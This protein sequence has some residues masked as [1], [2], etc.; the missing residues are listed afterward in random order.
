MKQVQENETTWNSSKKTFLLI[1]ALYLASSFVHVRQKPDEIR[2]LPHLVIGRI[3]LAPP[4]VLSG[5]SPHYLASVNSLLED[6]DFDLRNNYDQSEKGSLDLGERFRGAAI[7]RHV[8]RDTRGREMGTHSPFFALLLSLLL[9]PLS[10]S[11]WVEPASIWAG[12]LAALAGIF[13][14]GRRFSIEQRGFWMM[15][16]ALATPLWC[17]ARDLW[18]EPWILLIWV[19]M[20]AT[21][22][23]FLVCLLAF[24][25]TLIKYPFVVVPASMA[26]VYC[27]R[28]DWKRALALAGTSVL[29]IGLVIGSI[30]ILFQNVP[31]FSLFHSGVHAGFH[32]LPFRGGVGLLLDPEDGLL[33][34]FPFLAW[35]LLKFGRGG[36]LYLPALSFF[37]VHACYNDWT[38][39]TG[40][41]ARY[42]VPI[43]P[44]MLLAIQEG[45]PRDRFF[46]VALA[47][48]LF[49][50]AFGGFFPALVYDRTP[51]GVMAHL[52]RFLFPGAG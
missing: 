11:A 52:F 44:I 36:M 21:S 9:W 31:H 34:F 46:R 43:L 49:W 5:D 20:L 18:T 12:T 19:A 41:S 14:F 32:L 15:T 37:L 33:F 8:D 40:F 35:G 26:L 13:V 38:G 39:G 24:L 27:Y 48:G 28:K 30:Q 16:L 50:G 7:D 6:H 23:L 3:V 17:Y 45:R 42:L 51:W 29:A 22:N 25:G 4:T 1:C 47:Y 2:V 10:G